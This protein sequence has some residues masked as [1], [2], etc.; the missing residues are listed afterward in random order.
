M[1]EVRGCQEHGSPAWSH[2][3]KRLAFDALPSGK[4]S[5][6]IFL[7]NSDG[8]GLR[9]LGEN[10]MPCW[11]PD[12]KQLA[13]QTD[14]LGGARAGTWVQNVD[15]QGRN[16]IAEGFSPRWSPD[17]GKIAVTDLRLIKV[18]DL[19]DGGQAILHD[20]GYERILPGFGWSPDGKRFAL[21][22]QRGKQGEL[23]IVEAGKARARLARSGME[24][25]LAWSPD[26]KSIA[27]AINHRL[28]VLEVDGQD[29]PREIPNQEEHNTDPAWSP[30][31]SWIAFASDRKSP[32]AAQLAASRAWQ[33]EEVA[34]HPKGSIV[35]G[36]AFTPDGRRVVMG[37]DPES[38]GVQVWDPASGATRNLG[39]Q[40]IRVVMFPDGRRF[41][42]GWVGPTVQIVDLE[43]GDVV[44]EIQHGDTLRALDVSKDGTRLLSGGLDKL[45]HVWNADTGENLCTFDKHTHWLT[46][47]VF[48]PDGREVISAD[49]DGRLRVWDAKSGEQRL[50]IEHP[51]VVWGLAVSPDGRQILT[52][53]GGG[54]NRSPTVMVLNQGDDNVIRL[55]DATSGNLLR[56]MKGHTHAVFTLDISPDGR[57]AVSGGWD[58]TVRLW[59]LETG[60]QLSQSE[61]GQGGVMVVN[62]SPDGQQVL[63]GGGVARLVSGITDY[64]NEQI[65]VYRLVDAAK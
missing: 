11:S 25:R 8:T 35:Y 5:R 24:G 53:T 58:G 36:L 4:D 61:A 65:R 47:A 19:V 64:P 10:A 12:D 41:A 15:G 1:A 3:G 22:G 28:H 60:L 21:V 40:G 7:V 9:E 14:G 34:R 43:T 42:T 2:D 29:P 26:G 44:R 6:K 18:L 54:I 57:L 37:G 31:G 38:E 46:R 33:L 49:H 50:E 45:V 55:W 20:G 16:W 23:A 52:G 32:A 51:D 30:D 59:N 17:G 27:L 13:Y 48:S 56:E 62:F 63:A 39:G